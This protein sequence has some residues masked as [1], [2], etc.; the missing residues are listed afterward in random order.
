M[1][2]TR[3][4]LDTWTGRTALLV[5]CATLFLGTLDGTALTVALPTVQRDLGL[6]TTELQWVASANPLV[7]ASVTLL[8][9]AVADRFG[10]R[11]M[12]RLGLAVFVAG[13]LLCCV[14]PNAAWL[15][16]LRG[17]QGAGG[18][19]MT[20]PALALIANLFPGTAERGR[21]LGTWSATAGV[22][23]AVGPLAGGLLVQVAGWRSVFVVGVVVSAV[24]YA[25]TR[26]L[27]AS[28]GDPGRRIDGP[29]NLLASAVLI[30]LTFALIQ[31]A[32]HGWTSAWVLGAVALA[33]A[34]AVAYTASARRRREPV[35][36]P[37]HFRIPAIRGAVL[38]TIIA[39]LA[40]TGSSFVTMFYLQQVRGFP[41]L[42]AGVVTLPTTVG[43]LVL[44][45]VCGR[46]LGRLHGGRLPAALGLAAITASMALLAAVVAVDTWLPLL[47]AGYLLLGCGMGL[48]NPPS[49]NAAVTS[50]PRDRAGVA[51]AVTST[52][53]QV[54]S[55]LGV[56]VCGAVTVAVLAHA[57]RPT[58][59]LAAVAAAAPTDFAAALAVAYGLVAALAALGAAAAWRLFRPLSTVISEGSPQWHS[60]RSGASAAAPSSPSRTSSGSSAATSPRRESISS[61]SSRGPTT[62]S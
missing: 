30:G 56:A 26:L 55:N 54:G 5:C 43:T 10:R 28:G 2:G 22:S 33:V 23:S 45:T 16:A 14:A 48:V 42:V 41:P 19:L 15:I 29:G 57:G 24:V 20:P 46:L 18:A 35:L 25:G 51:S 37:A 50:L 31:G 4:G 36:D 62:T 61:S 12:F 1:G 44:A 52:S 17:V 58:G 39:Y 11:R 38:A 9:G 27:P 21:A 8:G 60:R 32:E 40:L 13:S 7:R 6:S 34:A 47:L 53:R 49:T 59:D 3:G